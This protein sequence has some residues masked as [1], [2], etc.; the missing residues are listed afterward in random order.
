MWAITTKG[1]IDFTTLWGA[2]A[3]ISF[4]IAMI[5]NVPEV[6]LWPLSFIN[7]DFLGLMFLIW[8]DVNKWG[9]STAYW[10]GPLLMMIA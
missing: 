10:I 3:S 9:A 7:S 6:I 8:S 5:L 4:I 2:G 1:E